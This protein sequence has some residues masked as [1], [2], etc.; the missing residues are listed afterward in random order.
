MSNTNERVDARTSHRNHA[1]VMREEPGGDGGSVK[2]QTQKKK[3]MLMLKD[4]ASLS[5]SGREVLRRR[6]RPERNERAHKQKRAQSKQPD[7]FNPMFAAFC[8]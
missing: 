2:T 4:E 1:N 5:P 7:T 6:V 8:A 3:K